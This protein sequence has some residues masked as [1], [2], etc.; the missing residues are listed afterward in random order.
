MCAP[1]RAML[2]TGNDNHIAGVGAQGE[3]SE[4][5]GYEGRLTDRVVTIPEILRAAG[6]HTYMAGKWHL[7]R[8]PESN[9]RERGFE[10]SFA[11]LN[12]AGNHYTNQSALGEG[13]S[14]YTEDGDSTAWEDGL[15]STDFYTDKLI[16]YIDQNKEDGQ[17]FFA[18]AAYTSP[19]W[20]L[21]VD[22]EYRKKYRGRY[23]E[24]YESLRERRLESLKNA[25]MI[26][27]HATLP[28][29]HETVV[30][31]GSLPE[32]EKKIEARKMELYAGMVDNLDVNIGRLIAY[33]KKEEMYEHTLFI[34]LSD[35]GAAYRDF[36][37]S[38]NY[39]VLR[40][41]YD[42]DFEN[43]GNPD[44]YISYGP[45]WAEAGSAP[46]R[47]FK[48]YATEGGTNTTMII[49][50]PPLKRHNEIHHGFTT[51]LDLAPTLYELAGAKYPE[52]WNATSVYPL[53]G[54]SLLPFLENRSDTIHNDDDVFALEHHGHTMVRKGDWKITNTVQPLDVRNFSLHYLPDD[55]GEQEDLKEKEP[56]KYAELLA[57]WEQYAKEI[58]LK[59][60]SSRVINRSEAP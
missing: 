34:F 3:V 51:V 48:D 9:P 8:T 53:K 37:N 6:Y 24:G 1:T 47:Y 12:G 32:E 38:D 50:G 2:L 44:S 15:Y 18:Y 55:P 16:G 42:D 45:Q 4:E 10:R 36:I 58:R 46:F 39:L 54:R 21:Q 7:G 17:P 59:E 19:H 41:Y 23:D 43:M 28:A 57:E 11:L 29:L 52:T 31:W 40:D 56:G 13:F 25:G 60:P 30:P 14:S 20:P 35:N 27:G 49:S 33:L 26:P 5:F 22:R